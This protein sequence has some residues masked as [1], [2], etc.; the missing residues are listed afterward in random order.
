MNER[1]TEDVLVQQTVAE[2][3]H[4][5]LG[6]DAVFAY[7]DETFGVGSTLGRLTQKKSSSP[8]TFS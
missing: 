7:N 8:N 3:F 1:L 6:W 2:Y 4:N 5:V